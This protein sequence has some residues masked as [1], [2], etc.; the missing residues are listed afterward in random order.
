MR[1][2]LVVVPTTGGPA[3]LRRLGPRAGLPVS[4]AFADGDY[5]P[6]AWVG[7]LRPA[8]GPGR[9]DR[10]RARRGAGAA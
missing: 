3:V 5:R 8:G 4:A 1:R 10:P 9:S 7:R 2:L 6:L